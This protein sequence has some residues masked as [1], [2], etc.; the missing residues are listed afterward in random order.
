[1]C[2]FGSPE[3][4]GG[5]KIRI[6]EVSS[7]SEKWPIIIHGWHISPNILALKDPWVPGDEGEGSNLTTVTG[8]FCKNLFSGTFWGDIQDYRTSVSA[9]GF[10]PGYCEETLRLGCSENGPLLGLWP[11]WALVVPLSRLLRL[12]NDVG[13]P[14]EPQ[15]IIKMVC[16]IIN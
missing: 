1:M 3:A 8:F 11:P 2:S 15:E 9:G 14:L 4:I 12:K 5:F 6:D 16:G 7:M 10:H 13:N